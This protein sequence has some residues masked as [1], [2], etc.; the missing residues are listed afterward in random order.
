MKKRIAMLLCTAALAAE[1]YYPS[2]VE[3]CMEGDSPRIRKV[4][5]LS[6]ADDPAGIP[7]GDF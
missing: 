4:Y 2:S 5:Q 6:L 3:T 7:T 1:R